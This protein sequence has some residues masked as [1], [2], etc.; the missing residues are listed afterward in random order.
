MSHAIPNP[1][2]RK[3]RNRGWR[4][5]R[6]CDQVTTAR[7]ALLSHAYRHGWLIADDGDEARVRFVGD[8]RDTLI[9]GRD[10]KYLEVLP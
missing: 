8:E 1:T 4:P 5:V 2:T 10:R 6:Y 9:R 3:V 7:G